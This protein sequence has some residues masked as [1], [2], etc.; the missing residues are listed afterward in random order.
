MYPK[1][2]ICIHFNDTLLFIGNNSPT[3]WAVKMKFAPLGSP[4][5]CTQIL[6]K[7]TQTTSFG[8]KN[9]EPMRLLLGYKN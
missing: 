4:L 3:Q 8:K 9:K 7:S 2:I 1:Y 5:K 6:P